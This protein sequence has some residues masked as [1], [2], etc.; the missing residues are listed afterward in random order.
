MIAEVNGTRLSY[1]VV[2][3]GPPLALCHSIGLSTRQ[4]W[5]EQV[6]WLSER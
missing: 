4:G 6:P 1:Q 5:R 2:G 3:Q